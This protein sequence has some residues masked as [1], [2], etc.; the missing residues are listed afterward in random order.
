MIGLWA[1]RSECAASELCFV[2]ISDLHVRNQSSASFLARAVNWLNDPRTFGGRK[3]SFVAVTGDLSDRGTQH[4]L[5]LCKIELSKLNVPYY[6]LPGNHDRLWLGLHSAYQ[7]VFPGR[8]RYAF[9]LNGYRFIF[10]SGA[11]TAFGKWLPSQVASAPAGTGIV[12][13]THYPYGKGVEFAI[14]GSSRSRV[15]N[16]MKKGHTL[17]VLSG[18]YHGATSKTQDGILFK[19]IPCLSSGRHN[20]DSSPIGAQ[21]YV[22][23]GSRI[24]TRFM[25]FPTGLRASK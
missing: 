19:T 7:K 11:P 6:V 17:A 23:D 12:V 8:D 13:L 15:I 14:S 5:E 24:T 25:P 1:L 4:E 10:D 20:R 16:E 21:L 2:Q 9:D 18:H 22:L 3:L